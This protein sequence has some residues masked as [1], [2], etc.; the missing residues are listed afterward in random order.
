MLGWER[1][2]RTAPEIANAGLRLLGNSELAF[3]ATVSKSGRPRI[4]PF[5]PKVVRGRLVAFII[6]SSPKIKDLQYRKQYSIHTLPGPEDEECFL[7]GEA[8][9]CY[10]ENEFRLEAATAMGFVT[11][12]DEH[13]ILYEFF[14]DR[15]LW[16]R[17]LDFGTADHRAQHS[18][19]ALD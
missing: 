6:D 9:E 11:G 10:S 19:W 12:V 16:T 8:T 14:L 5:V 7:S 2:A 15:A 4:H 13:H 18:R 1:F 3:L 17:W